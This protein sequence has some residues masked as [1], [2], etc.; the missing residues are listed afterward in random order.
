MPKL[1]PIWEEHRGVA[2]D[3]AEFDRLVEIAVAHC[4]RAG[5]HGQA[6]VMT[7]NRLVFAREDYGAIRVIDCAVRRTA[8]LNAKE[9]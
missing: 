6:C 2:I 4:R 8:K 7:D 9:D 5:E 3:S 1:A